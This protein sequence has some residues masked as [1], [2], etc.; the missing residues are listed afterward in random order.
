MGNCQSKDRRILTEYVVSYYIREQTKDCDFSVPQDICDMCTEYYY[1]A[2]DS[3]NPDLVSKARV[4][5]EENTISTTSDNEGWS[6]TSFLMEIIEYGKF[7][8]KFK[9]NKLHGTLSTV[10]IWKVNDVITEK[11]KTDTNAFY[12]S[13][14]AYAF[15][16]DSNDLGGLHAN[17]VIVMMLDMNAQTLTF[18]VNNE[19]KHTIEIGPGRYRAAFNLYQPSDSV[20]ILPN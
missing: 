3:W 9:V 4:I 12:S 14:R 7:E 13:C 17:D 19:H 8:W 6:T 5:L 10:G 18:Q 15:G 16:A 11:S 20:S 2:T 1:I